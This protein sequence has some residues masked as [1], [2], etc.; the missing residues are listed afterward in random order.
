MADDDAAPP[1]LSPEA[2]ARRDAALARVRKWGDP[3]L[4]TAA[5][6]VDRFDDEL[7]AE[8]ARMARLM[9]DALGAGLAAP[10]LGALRRVV[11]Y[12]LGPEAPLGVLVNPVIEWAGDELEVFEEGCLSVPGVWFEVER[13]A[14]VRVRTRD[15]WGEE[16][17]I[18]A[19]GPEA[20]VL[21]HE[22]DHLDGLLVLDR[23]DREQRR[24]AVRSL[25]ER[26][27]VA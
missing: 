21:Q 25:R 18:E 6:P 23:V 3:V 10:Q 4:R 9:D 22:I 13:P 11:V 24:A 19:A 16:R 20:S 26:L 15:E 12:R 17:V 27:S 7:R 5:R 8:V 14:R 2:A 1:P